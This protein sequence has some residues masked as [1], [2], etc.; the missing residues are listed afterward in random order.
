[1]REFNFLYCHDSGYNLQTYV[2]IFSFLKQMKNSELN[3]YILHK[4]PETFNDYKDKLKKFENINKIEIYKFNKDL[5]HFPNLN[6]KHVS[7]ATYYRLF[8]SEFLPENLK[9][10]IYVD[11]DVLC[12]NN[13]EVDFENTFNDLEKFNKTIAVYPEIIKKSKDHDLFSNLELQYDKYFNAGVMFINFEKWAK[14]VSVDKLLEFVEIYK[15]K[16]IFWDQDI[17]NKY[18]DGN[19]VEI[20]NILNF[21]VKSSIPVNSFIDNA[22]LI[23]YAGNHKPWTIEAGCEE[24]STIFFNLYQELNLGYYFFTKKNRLT[25]TLISIISDIISLKVFRTKYPMKYIKEAIK[26]MIS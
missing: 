4:E 9:K 18:F 5:S 24:S 19:Y 12:I 8:I 25:K 15:E 6:K 1:V 23:H 14:E 10:I 26:T 17:L 2:S 7:E 20:K 22:K 3:I 21:S 11:S 13:P 16:I